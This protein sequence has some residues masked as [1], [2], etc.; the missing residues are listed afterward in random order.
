[1]YL[2]R[3]PILSGVFL[4]QSAAT[5]DIKNKTQYKM[6]RELTHFGYCFRCS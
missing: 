2:W 4:P 3:L 1:M 6:S 5:L